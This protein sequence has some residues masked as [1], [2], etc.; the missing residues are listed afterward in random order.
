ML[1][2]P[3]VTWGRQV[4]LQQPRTELSV[5]DLIS[6]I[7]ASLKRNKALILACGAL[8]LAA[9]LAFSTLATPRFVAQAQ[10][11]VDPRDLVVF[12]KEVRPGQVTSDT[13]TTIVESQTRVLESDNVLKRA[14][15]IMKLDQDPEFNGTRQSALRKI[16]QSVT[17]FGSSS[18]E[19]PD[20]ALAA[21]RTLQQRV[22]VSRPERTFIVELTVWTEDRDKSVEVANA[23]VKAF[24]A[25]QAD[26]RS[27]PARQTE[28]AINAGIE[29]LR[30]R[31]A[32]SEELVAKYKT[33]NNLVGASGRLVNE[34]QLTEINNQLVA[35]RADMSKA[36]VKYE[37]ARRLRDNPDVIP[38]A[39][40]SATLR[41]LRTQMAG[42]T[43]QKAKLASQLKPQHPLMRAATDQENEIRAQISD[44]LK[45]I[46]KSSQVEFD[47]AKA[48]E[49]LLASNMETL[50]GQMNQSNDAQI[51]L[52]ELESELDANR[53]IYSAAISRARESKEQSRLNTTNIR[54]ITEPSPAKSRTF[55]PPK[56][57]LLPAGLMLGL[58]F[59]AALGL[60]RDQ[61][62]K[63]GQAP[64]KVDRARNDQR[65][66]ER[67]VADVSP[68]VAAE[69]VPAYRAPRAAPPK[70]TPASTVD[71]PRASKDT[72]PLPFA[73]LRGAAPDSWG[74]E[75]ETSRKIVDLGLSVLNAPDSGIG[76]EISKLAVKLD[77]MNAATGRAR[78]PQVLLVASDE[79][80]PMKSALS[81][82]LA[83]A[84]FAKDK[85]VLLVDADLEERRLS[86]A[87]QDTRRNGTAEVM[88]GTAPLISGVIQRPGSSLEFLPVVPRPGAPRP[89][90]L[91]SAGLRNLVNQARHYDVV[92]I[93]LPALDAPFVEETFAESGLRMVLALRTPID[94]QDA[95][96]GAM[97]MLRRAMPGMAGLVITD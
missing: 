85:R 40:N 67:V 53:A 44:E 82:G 50:R 41:Q 71:S 14:I 75:F 92:I 43:S 29:P 86:E 96:L 37:E 17:S 23:I 84:A 48:V 26:A 4:P 52:R 97:K 36:K 5:N 7:V 31:V 70:V 30:K 55:P 35:A 69:P 95:L 61:F 47:R 80:N 42:I 25:E 6:T 62:R 49:A 45:R 46:V 87:M 15:A 60:A 79:E 59:G 74:D 34:Q 64:N 68:P 83:N 88:A 91:T 19:K 18:T 65:P 2:D 3:R 73:N 89:G 58:G 24:L 13:A 76:S 54:V 39:V 51:K 94:R 78:R 22:W 57:L 8:G 21:L 1:E 32:V 33:D 72:L 93:E 56:L 12:D 66:R 27:E 81:L 20:P 28:D 90:A 77:D 10:L 38:E 11:L 9:A 63:D 16:L